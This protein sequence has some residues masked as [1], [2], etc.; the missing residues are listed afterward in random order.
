VDILKYIIY[1]SIVLA[2]SVVYLSCSDVGT[3]TSKLYFGSGTV[4]YI[5]YTGNDFYGIVTDEGYGLDPYPPLPE[6]YQ[7]DGLRVEVLAETLDAYTAHMWGVPVRILK[8]R[9]L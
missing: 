2:I 1:I 8:I 7:V 5:T 9:R 4:E 3:E 6:E